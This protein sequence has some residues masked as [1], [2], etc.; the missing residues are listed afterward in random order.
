[1]HTKFSAN[2]LLEWERWFSCG[3]IYFLRWRPVFIYSEPMKKLGIKPIISPV[4]IDQ[5]LCW[6][7][8][9]HG[10]DSITWKNFRTVRDTV[11]R[12]WKG[13]ENQHLRISFDNHAHFL[14]L[15]NLKSILPTLVHKVNTFQLYNQFQFC[16]YR[17]GMNGITVYCILIWST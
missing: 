7:E 14:S 16:K 11:H 8:D 4:L 3:S 1:M 15:T 12:M 6:L 2:Y 10:S 13:P 5:L 9:S 17:E